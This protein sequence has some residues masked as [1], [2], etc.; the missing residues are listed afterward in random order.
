MRKT[1]VIGNAGGGKTT[2]CE[3]LQRIY[4][5]PYYSID[6]ILWRE[7]WTR[8]PIEEVTDTI[9][10]IMDE[11]RWIIDGWGPMETIEERFK[12]CDSIVLIDLPLHMHLCWAFKRQILAWIRPSSVK[13]PKS[14]PLIG[15][16]LSVLKTVYR[17]DADAIPNLR[18]LVSKYSDSTQIYHLKS[19]R[20]LKKFL[21]DQKQS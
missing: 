16:T 10:N 6:N 3:S 14:C 7:N 4:N 5:I 15:K 21:S 2:L 9:T 8:A 18:K 20:A 11:D 17:I 1:A 12:R 19:K 13:I